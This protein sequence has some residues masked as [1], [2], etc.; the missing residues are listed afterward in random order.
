MKSYKKLGLLILSL[1]AAG[2]AQ[3]G[4]VINGTNEFVRIYMPVGSDGRQVLQTA[5]NWCAQHGRIAANLKVLIRFEEIKYD[6]VDKPGHKT[7]RKPT[8]RERKISS[9][10]GFFISTEGH[11]ITNHHVV[12]GCRQ[13]KINGKRVRVVA[14]DKSD[15]LALLKTD[16]SSDNFTRFSM[17]RSVRLGEDVIV[18]G[19][20]LRGLLGSGLNVTKG[21]VSALKRIGND[22]RLTQIT[23]PVQPGNSGG[24]V[25]DGS[26]NMV[27]VVVSKLDAIKTAKRIGTLP[28]NVNFVIKGATARIFLDS[29]NIPY[30]TARL[31]RPKST[32]DIAAEARKYTVLVECWK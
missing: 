17:G 18:A 21:T 14:S 11:L 16:L 26:G 3:G 2:C 15:D 1:T 30:K 12:D 20:P 23:A 22:R 8:N 6:C 32:S 29:E 28:E 13:V 24:P 25:L 5:H 27:G 4:I 7:A 19:F 10:S 31:G 9:G